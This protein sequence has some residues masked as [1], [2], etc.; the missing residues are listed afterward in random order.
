MKTTASKITG[1]LILASIFV[2]CGAEST[3]TP[4]TTESVSTTTTAAETDANHPVFPEISYDGDEILF[5]T[6]DWRFGDIYDSKEIYAESIDGSLI[7]DAVY[8]RN[9]R[10]QEQFDVV[11]KA[12]ILPLASE[13]AFQNIMAGDNTYDVVMPYLNSSVVNALEGLYLDLNCIENLHLENSW[14]D[15]NAN[16]ILQIDDKLYFTTGDI[17]I[18]DNE[19]MLVLFFNKTVI[20]DFD[21]ESPYDLVKNGTWTLDA[22]VEMRDTVNADLN[23]DGVLKPDDDRFGLYVF[24]NTPLAMFF[25]SGERIV[26]ADANGKQQLVMYNDRSASV[27]DRCMEVSLDERNMSCDYTISLKAFQEGRLL[28]GAWAL[29]EIQSLRNCEQDFGVLPFPKY[30]EAQEN[31]HCIISTSLTPAV[32][33]PITNPNPSQAGLILEAMAY[34]SVDTVTHAYYD[35]SLNSRFI[36]DEESSE[37]FDIMFANSVY[38]FGYIFDVGGLGMILENMFYN[39]KNT[40]SSRYASME[41][42]A[43]AALEDI[44]SGEH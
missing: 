33:I 25:A 8:N 19:C 16:K 13:V 17:S 34:Y 2:S 43:L 7:N 31:Y 29:T 1:L 9:Q 44:F 36:R 23:G 3:G 41:K 10:V 12:E 22:L 6:E 24:A 4:N 32:S 5:L 37:M 38:D 20:A 35:L 30:D 26:S 15:Q 21:L 40:F 11:I 18:L 42:K 28:F 39:K 14:W 27:I